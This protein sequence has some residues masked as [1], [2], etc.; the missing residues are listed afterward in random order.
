MV[1]STVTYV[2]RP[3][4]I[5][6]WAA[7]YDACHRHS[8]SAFH[9]HSS[10]PEKNSCRDKILPFISVMTRKSPS[11]S[12]IRKNNCPPS[13]TSMDCIIAVFPIRS[14]HG[15]GLLLPA[16]VRQHCSLHNCLPSSI[17]LLRKFSLQQQDIHQR[18]P[19]PQT[20]Q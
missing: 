20:E 7:L 2:T 13:H 19:Q 4:G 16:P 9:E 10:W 17:R 14:L 6:P 5:P 3:H 15:K 8:M 11:P 18:Q 12:L 1:D